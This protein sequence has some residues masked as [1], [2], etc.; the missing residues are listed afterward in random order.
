MESFC[1]KS[2]LFSSTIVFFPR[3]K[4]RISVSSSSKGR[5][6]S[7]IMITK[8]AVS[9]Y[10]LD[11]STPIFSTTSPV[12]RIPAVS[13]ILMGIPSIFRYSSTVSLVVPGI[14][15]TI[16]RS[17]SS[18]QF[19]KEDFPTFGLPTMTVCKPSRMILPRSAPSSSFSILTSSFFAP[20]SIV[21]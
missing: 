12:S 15:V 2:T 14:S 21:P 16:A 3:M 17:S 1:A 6:P 20:C 5:E 4:E 8:S 18:S 10:A 9:A 13:T 19:N 11:F 7:S